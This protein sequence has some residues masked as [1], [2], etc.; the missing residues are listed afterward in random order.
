VCRG[1]KKFFNLLLQKLNRKDIDFV[2]KISSH[3]QYKNYFKRLFDLAIAVPLMIV[4]SPALVLIGFMVRR[5][6]GKPV[7]FRQ[8]RPGLRGMPFTI[9]KFRTMTDVRDEDG[10]LLTD[11]ERLA[12]LGRFLRK[13]SLDELPELWNVLKG[14][15]SLVGPRPLLVEYLDRYTPEQARRHEVK[16]GMTGWAQVNGNTLLSW[17]ER[18]FLDVWYIDHWSLLLDFKIIFKTLKVLIKG[19][20]KNNKALKEAINYANNIDGGC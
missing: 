7:F 17:D 1:S 11:G 19:E 12:G 3:E 13:L 8:V 14:D 2:R 10:N 15:M 5:R 4:F 16:P 9:Y 6:I 18:C 20:E